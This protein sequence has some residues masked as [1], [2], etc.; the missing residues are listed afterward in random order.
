HV[1]VVHVFRH[2]LGREQT[3]AGG[4]VVAV[5]ERHDRVV[6]RQEVQQ[7]GERHVDWA[8]NG[9]SPRISRRTVEPRGTP[10]PRRAS[11][12]RLPVDMWVAV[13]SNG[14]NIEVRSGSVKANGSRYRRRPPARV[15]RYR[16]CRIGTPLNLRNSSSRTL[17]SSMTRW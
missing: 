5:R 14:R 2:E 6:R 13:F 17:R 3:G 9:T 1:R 8:S 4:I 11:M 7:S 15:K 10:P 16:S 12:W